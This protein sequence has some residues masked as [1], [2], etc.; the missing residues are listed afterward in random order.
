MDAARKTLL[1]S[2]F[3]AARI[4]VV[5]PLSQSAIDFYLKYG[6][7]PLKADGTALYIA[8]ETIAGGL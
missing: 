2:R 3:T 7:K 5:H 6:F 1:G 4:L 8:V